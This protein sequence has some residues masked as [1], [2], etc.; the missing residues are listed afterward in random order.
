ML[1]I[2]LRVAGLI[3]RGGRDSI[4]LA[5]ILAKKG[6]KSGSFISLITRAVVTS[7]CGVVN[8]VRSIS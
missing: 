7:A 6:F 5:S 4:T 8:P 1:G 2:S 3:V